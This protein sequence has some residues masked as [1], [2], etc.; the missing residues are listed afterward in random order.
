MEVE[1]GRSNGRRGICFGLEVCLLPTS[2][3]VELD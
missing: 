1:L 3:R 2:L